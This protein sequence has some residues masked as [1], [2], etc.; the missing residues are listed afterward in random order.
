MLAY[1]ATFCNTNPVKVDYGE[2]RHSCDDPVCPE[3]RPEA[4]ESELRERGDWTAGRR[5]L[6]YKS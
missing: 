6:F 4:A 3:P 1:V 2:V 5:S